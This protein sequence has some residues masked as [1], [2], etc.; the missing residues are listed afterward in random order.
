MVQGVSH[1]EAAAAISKAPP[2]NMRTGGATRCPGMPAARMA[3]ISPSVDM[4]VSVIRVAT[5][6]PM[7]TVKGSDCGSTRKNR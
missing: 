3:V 4:R 5:S 6:T 7:G 2:P 1:N